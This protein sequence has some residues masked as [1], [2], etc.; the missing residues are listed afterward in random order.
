[1]NSQRLPRSLWF[2]RMQ[3]LLP[4]LSRLKRRDLVAIVRGI[5]PGFWYGARIPTSGRPNLMLVAIIARYVV[6][7]VGYE[8]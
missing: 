6:Y 2:D 1:M 3:R 4:A 7:R 8:L 5:D